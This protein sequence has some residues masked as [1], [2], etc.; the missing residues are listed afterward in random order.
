MSKFAG[1]DPFGSAVFGGDPSPFLLT[2]IDAETTTEARRLMARGMYDGTSLQAVEFSVGQ[3]GF[4]PASFYAAVPVNPDAT[5]L[6]D[7]V[8]TDTIDHIEPPNAKARSYY[9][10]LDTTEANV[11]LGE[12]AIWGEVQ[13][14]PGDPAD[15]TKI[16][17]AIGHFP[18][19]CKNSSMQYALRVT[20]LA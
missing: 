17:M 14:S 10:L 8:F 1:A 20:H 9:C 13:N 7:S 3:D 6:D 18:L 4:D 19:I 2:Q 12:I 16:I 5:A 15:G 11:T